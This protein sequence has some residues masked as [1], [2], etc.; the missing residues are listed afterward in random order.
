MNDIESLEWHVKYARKEQIKRLNEYL[1]ED[2]TNTIGSFLT[3]GNEWSE[4]SLIRWSMIYIPK[5]KAE[6]EESPKTF[7]QKLLRK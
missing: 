7:W 4:D 6:L 3:Q 5:I 2:P 1:E